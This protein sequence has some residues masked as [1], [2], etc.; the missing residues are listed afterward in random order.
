MKTKKEE[1]FEGIVL[2]EIET[3]KIKFGKDV[4]SKKEKK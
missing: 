1:E 4:F 2:A 3:M